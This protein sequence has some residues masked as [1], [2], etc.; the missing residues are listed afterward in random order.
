MEMD[1][2]FFLPVKKRMWEGPV[3]EFYDYEF[4]RIS[5]PSI[6]FHPPFFKPP[7][8]FN[9]APTCFLNALFFL[10]SISHNTVMTIDTL[11][12]FY[13]KV[14]SRLI[15]LQPTLFMNSNLLWGSCQ[16]CL[17]KWRLINQNMGFQIGD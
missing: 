8:L 14:G 12:H 2:K 15:P 17:K 6:P 9:T 13:R 10:S 1:S 7:S 3:G 11:N 16:I 4:L 5:Y